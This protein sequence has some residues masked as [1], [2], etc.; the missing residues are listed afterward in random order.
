MKKLN[1]INLQKLSQAELAKHEENL[2]KGGNDYTC[3]C[4][5]GAICGCKYA[6]SQTDPNDPFYGGSGTD[7]NYDAIFDEQVTHVNY[8]SNTSVL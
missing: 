3:A 6:G 1:R 8:R 5:G 2:L 4:A 7:D